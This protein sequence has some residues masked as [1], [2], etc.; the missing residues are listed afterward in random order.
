M[1]KN[2][3]APTQAFQGLAQEAP[4]Q[5]F[6]SLLPQ[7][8]QLRKQLTHH[9]LMA[10]RRSKTA[11]QPIP[12]ADNAVVALMR[13]CRE[14]PPVGAHN[15]EEAMHLVAHLTYMV[16]MVRPQTNGDGSKVVVLSPQVLHDFRHQ[17]RDIIE[18]TLTGLHAPSG[19]SPAN[20]DVMQNQLLQAAQKITAELL[21]TQNRPKSV[22]GVVREP[23]IV[24][25][26]YLLS[27]DTP[28]R[29]V[30]ALSPAPAQLAVG[31]QRPAVHQPTPP[32]VTFAPNRARAADVPRFRGVPGVSIHLPHDPMPEALASIKIKWPKEQYA[33][34][35]FAGQQ[36][37]KVYDAKGRSFILTET[38][39]Q[40]A[41]GKARRAYSMDEPNLELVVKEMRHV[42][43]RK[44]RPARLQRTRIISRADAVVEAHMTQS[45]RR[46]IE[47]DMSAYDAL[48]IEHPDSLQRARGEVMPFV[49]HGLIKNNAKTYIVMS[50]DMG[51]ASSLNGQMIG[52]NKVFA[53]KSLAAQIF[54]ELQAMHET[55][56]VAHL[57]ISDNNIFVTRSGQ[58]KI[59][60][61]G[62][63]E[64]LAQGRTDKNGVRGTLLAPENVGFS[65]KTD[66]DFNLTGATDVFA[67]AAMVAVFASGRP[68]DNVFYHGFRMPG[69]RTPQESGQE[70][71]RAFVAWRQAVADPNS[72]RITAAGILAG[73]DDYF[74]PLFSPLAE[75]A[76]QLCETLINDAMAIAPQDRKSA[77]ELAHVVRGLLPKSTDAR[78]SFVNAL[79]S[80]DSIE[81]RQEDFDFAAMFDA[82]ETQQTQ[83][84]QEQAAATRGQPRNLP[85]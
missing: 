12:A 27:P 42:G 47:R 84:H 3:Q 22:P 6:A 14:L 35:P 39:A 23:S 53:V 33:D 13:L 55:C 29:S 21:R 34:Q 26:S 38:F 50:A 52:A 81:D 16:A 46:N 65:L 66:E 69:T 37:S 58:F 30:K 40:G 62:G 82:W 68:R 54:S 78:D 60:D 32:R 85:G 63:A 43:S 64:P 80:V 28:P 70:M 71:F 24:G 49:M 15:V 19:Q 31:P 17:T 36:Y 74:S 5:S 61:H 51:S 18:A 8:E 83:K 2:R 41:V 57:D 9:G 73:E 56:N 20:I 44:L 59:M 48:P 25:D 11:G 45:I 72:G 10:L 4:K 67:A 75:M 1:I 79:K 7:A 76:P 77:G